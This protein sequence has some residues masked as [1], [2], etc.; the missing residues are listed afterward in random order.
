[1]DVWF[2]IYRASTDSQGLASLALPSGVYSVDASKRGYE[3]HPRLIDIKK[4]E[5]VRLEAVPSAETHPDD[6]RVWM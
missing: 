3:T 6:S 1:V 2:G 5:I 4:D